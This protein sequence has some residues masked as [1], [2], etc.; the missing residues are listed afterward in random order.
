MNDENP[1][2]KLLMLKAKTILT[3]RKQVIEIL[4]N[5]KMMN[6]KLIEKSARSK[7]DPSPI[8]SAMST[9][10]LKYPITLDKER[11]VK[12]GVPSIY[13]AKGKQGEDKHTH[14]RILCKKEAIDWWVERS[15]IPSKEV[16]A[17][18]DILYRQSKEEV[19]RYYGIDWSESRIKYGPPVIERR[20]VKTKTPL[21]E[22][23]SSIQNSLIKETLFPDLTIP[24]KRI[25][26]NMKNDARELVTLALEGKLTL[27]SQIRILLSSLDPKVRCLPMIPG[28]SE[29]TA[30]MKHSLCHS[31]FVI[32]NVVV[33]EREKI[34]T[35]TMKLLMRVLR[36]VIYEAQKHRWD[37]ETIREVLSSY[38]IQGLGVEEIMM[39][40]DEK[41]SIEVKFVKAV[42]GLQDTLETV[43]D[44]M[45][46]CP[47]LSN[48][49]IISTRNKAGLRFHYNSS[50]E[51]TNFK[52]GDVKGNFSHANCILI[53]VTMNYTC[54]KDMVTT[55]SEIAI[56]I[57]WNFQN[58]RG[59]TRDK[60]H[61][62]TKR[63]VISAPWNL[64][65]TTKEKFQ[66]FSFGNTEKTPI[67]C[68]VINENAEYSTTGKIKL[69]LSSNL[70]L[71]V[72]GTNQEIEVS[73][74][75][76]LLRCYTEEIECTKGRMLAYFTFKRMVKNR[77]LFFLENWKTV[78]SYVEIGSFKWEN[79]YVVP[80]LENHARSFSKTCRQ[81]LISLIEAEKWD[82]CYC[83][84]LYIFVNKD[85]HTVDSSPTS[86]TTSEGY[87]IDLH[88]QEGIFV[89][90]EAKKHYYLFGTKAPTESEK[91]DIGESF[92]G[93]LTGYKITS[94]SYEGLKTVSLR[95]LEE[96][97]DEIED[98]DKH[99]IFLNGVQY[100]AIKDSSLAYVHV[101]TNSRQIY[102]RRLN[103]EDSMNRIL[104]EKRQWLVGRNDDDEPSS[105]KAR[106]EINADDALECIVGSSFEFE[107]LYGN[108]E[109]DLD[110]F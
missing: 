57:K 46:T 18:I 33:A 17:S 79:Q 16:Q 78:K 34:K 44:G 52:Y 6:L 50:E 73:I 80:Y 100:T 39:N 5:Q 105:K 30:N 98:G 8:N 11:A 62:E 7:K 51:T 103:H 23:P 19:D 93:C 68:L 29:S 24:D 41:N 32:T 74:Q 69:N 82:K 9:M 26:P 13:L 37:I 87:H 28:S 91:Y 83:C 104:A 90:R 60:I 94:T 66:S 14:G 36:S 95:R 56:Y 53:S 72:E 88:T 107:Q 92:N 3:S 15:D 4:R 97:Y 58:S 61:E 89:Y 48:M 27:S 40:N 86:I 85:P 31:N 21:F 22:I 55:L 99:K 70:N 1:H 101:Q 42:F 64:I 67:G 63:A 25:T 20:Y 43:R 96:I 77:Y 12:Y 54:K 84:F 38:K 106:L 10:G 108:D 81:V 2:K 71:I 75:K 102:E 59:K 45:I 35:D 65:S 49:R 47:R 109:W 110:Q 76:E